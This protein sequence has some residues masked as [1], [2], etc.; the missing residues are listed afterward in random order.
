MDGAALAEVEVFDMASTRGRSD[1]AV[2]ERYEARLV[3][4]E[5][6][7]ANTSQLNEELKRD[8]DSVRIQI[9][10][11]D[12]AIQVMKNTEQNSTLTLNE[13]KKLVEA[14]E[15]AYQ[16]TQGMAILLRL[17]WVIIGGCATAL[18]LKVMGWVRP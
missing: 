18:V 14:H 17:M 8:R 10:Q 11:M 6:F 13:M 1:T 7:V 2:L 5:A 15:R 12:S 4:I 16:R 9:G 3:L